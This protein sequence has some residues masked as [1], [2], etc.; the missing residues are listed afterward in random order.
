MEK[1]KGL[2]DLLNYFSTF[3]S[4]FAASRSDKPQARVAQLVERDLAKVEVASSNL[5]SRS[6]RTLPMQRPFLLL[7]QVT[8]TCRSGGT[9][10]HEGLKIPC[11]HERTGS[12]PV[13]GTIT[14]KPLLQSVEEAFCFLRIQ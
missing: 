5:V 12:I 14:K 8:C 13:S 7:V 10:R 2:L 4:P 1:N 6:K 3:V 9:G 11:F